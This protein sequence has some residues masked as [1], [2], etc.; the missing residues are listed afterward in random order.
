MK[1]VPVYFSEKSTYLRFSS[2]SAT[3]NSSGKASVTLRTGGESSGTQITVR[4]SGLSSKSY[5]VR[6]KPFTETDTKSFHIISESAP[7]KRR[8]FGVCVS[9]STDLYEWSKTVSFPGRV[10]DH[11]VSG[12]LDTNDVLLG[13][14]GEITGSR[15]SGNTVTVRGVIE[16]HVNIPNDIRGEVWAK[17]EAVAYSP[18]APSLQQPQ[19]HPKIDQLSMFW[20]DMSQV[21]SETVLLPNYPNPFNP[22]TGSR[23]ISLK[24]T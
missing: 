7:C 10:L 5:T 12:G 22:E 3:T 23:I 14:E 9:W 19:L 4:P 21:P 8:I 6:I 13:G 20:K 15:R 17:Y 24:L 16:R 11:S 2:S 1:G 18:G